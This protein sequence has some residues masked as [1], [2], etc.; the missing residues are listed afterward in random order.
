F[1]NELISIVTPTKGVREV[2]LPYNSYYIYEWIGIMQSKEEISS[3]PEQ[4]FFS[5]SPGDL[6]IKD[7]NGDNVV[8]AEDRISI[9]P[10]PDF[11]YSFGV[12]TE[13]KGLGLSLFFQG[14][15]GNK[16]QLNGWGWDPFVQGDPP[17]TRFY[18]AW[19]P[20]N[21]SNTVPAIYNGWGYGGV[22]S[23]P[24]T[25]WLHDLSYLRLKNV[26]LSYTLPE[27]IL[28]RIKFQGATVYLS[29]D[30]LLTITNYEGADP[31][32][33]GSGGGV[34]GS[35]RYAQYPQVR[36]LNMGMNVRF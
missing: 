27:S 22:S 21:P 7:Q 14:S 11:T 34:G 8:D 36:I 23:Y 12:N 32:T 3:S 15:Q 13:W 18:D 35:R 9:S 17:T 20:E 31:E 29:G 26:R 16:M 28:D 33:L 30:N 24:S 4:L 6:K 10:Y 5:P 25:Y 1:K 19:T 2:G